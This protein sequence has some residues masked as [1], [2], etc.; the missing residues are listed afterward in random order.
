MLKKIIIF[1]TLLFLYWTYNANAALYFW[2]IPKWDTHIIYENDVVVL[3]NKYLTTNS[4]TIPDIKKLQNMV[5]N[6]ILKNW[7]WSWI[8]R[9]NKQLST[10]IRI[11]GNRLY[12]WCW[13]IDFWYFILNTNKSTTSST[14]WF[15]S[16]YISSWSP[17]DWSDCIINSN[18]LNNWTIKCLQTT[19][20]WNSNKKQCW[21]WVTTVTK[22]CVAWNNNCNS[23][24]NTICNTSSCPTNKA[25]PNNISENKTIWL[26]IGNP[27][28]TCNNIYANDSK[29]CSTKFNIRWTTNQNKPIIWLSWNSVLNILDLS[30]IP[31][32]RTDW[33]TFN[34][35][36]NNAI[37]I[38]SN[39]TQIVWSWTNF[40]FTIS[41]I[42]AISP[43]TSNNWILNFKLG[44]Q[45]FIVWWLNY[46]FIK[47]ISWKLQI[48]EWWS[49]PEIWK[50]QKYKIE[51]KNEWNLFNYSNW[52]VNITDTTVKNKT[53]WH[54]WNSFSWVKKD[55]WNDI[56]NYLWFIWNIDATSNLLNW[57][58]VW[59][60]NITVSYNLSWKNVKY[61]LD[62]PSITWC[63]VS[64]LWLR[65]EWT[66]QWDWKWGETWQETNFTDI[67][68]LIAR[69][70]I[71]QNAYKLIKNRVS[72]SIINWVKYIDW[73]ITITWSQNFETLIVKNWNVTISWNLTNNNKTLWIVVLKDNYLVESDYNIA[74][75]VYVNNNVTTIDAIIYADWTF[76]SAKS[77]WNGYLDNELTSTLELFWSLF[78]RNTIW[79]AVISS[80]SYTIPGWQATTN[81]DLAEI[82]DLNYIRKINNICDSDPENDYSFL[83]KYNP[84]IQ[85][86]PP[87]WFTN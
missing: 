23:K 82:Y 72:W 61:Y 75:N 33:L 41:D 44:N 34:S 73:D 63:N 56:L 50:D 59:T 14:W 48:I 10:L 70:N 85:I 5:S 22:R 77:N 29:T 16:S 30:K 21:N 24:S 37:N 79:W 7:G 20:S 53:S 6:N 54:F 12:V 19:T 3:V 84:N 31:S 46:N 38:G 78:T 83:I 17:S 62:M 8:K 71:K 35:I 67:S 43:F 18:W 65:V 66:L 1:I 55:F 32:N 64:T 9:T 49:T 76:R 2:T 28:E 42:R 13:N 52:K 57:A 87:K 45:D 39:S 74:W 58:E 81:Y 60:N 25:Y 4:W 51:L 80:T 26:D 68:K 69:G 47:P 36:T 15:C 40:S 27:V 86:N 11:K